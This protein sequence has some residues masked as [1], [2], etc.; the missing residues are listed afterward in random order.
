M[1]CGVESVCFILT[2]LVGKRHF[3][4]SHMHGPF[5]ETSIFK[6]KY[7]GATATLEPAI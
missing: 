5:S 6:I 4:Q 1:H 7:V 3:L 2:A